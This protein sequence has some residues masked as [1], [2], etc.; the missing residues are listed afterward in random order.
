MVNT[1]G[2]TRRGRKGEEALVFLSAWVQCLGLSLGS[3]AVRTSEAKAA[4]GLRV[5][6][7][8]LGIP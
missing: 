7:G 1:Y 4:E 3:A 5:R 6:M 8:D 2:G